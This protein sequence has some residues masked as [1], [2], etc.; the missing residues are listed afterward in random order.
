MTI[1]T[2]VAALA[3]PPLSASALMTVSEALQSAFPGCEIERGT[4][5]PTDDELDKASE[6]AGEEIERP[7]V[8][9]YRAI[10]DGEHAGTAYFDTHRV[11]TLPET[12]MVAVD[13]DHEVRRVELLVFKEPPDYIPGS[14]WYGQFD[15]ERLDERLRLKRDIHPIA[16]ATL[17]ARATTAAVRRV[18]AVHR[19]LDER[20]ASDR[21]KPS[22]RTARRAGPEPNSD[23]DTD[24][25][26]RGP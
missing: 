23:S 7:V 5:Y 14:D 13:P 16:G 3:P 20:R 17:T 4:M 22:S 9:P 15:S 10:C 18:L 12:L 21:S 19:V 11:R 2:V 25:E 24:P 6:L 26:D 1:L 8:H